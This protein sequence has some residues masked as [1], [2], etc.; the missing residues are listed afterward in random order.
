MEKLKL[1]TVTKTSSDETLQIGDIIWLSV[2]GDLHN[3]NK[4]FLSK[5][6]WYVSGTNDFE[7]EECRTHH[8]LVLDGYETVVKN[9]S[10]LLDT[11]SDTVMEYRFYYVH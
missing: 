6:Q 2:N 7:V 10:W 3:A 4:G 5:D 9:K 11:K 8:L 1:Y